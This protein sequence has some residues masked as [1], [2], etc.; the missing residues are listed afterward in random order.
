M[1]KLLTAFLLSTALA[2]IGTVAQAQSPQSP[3]SPLKQVC[4]YD[5]KS[6]GEGESNP[7]GQVCVAG[8][9][10]TAAPVQTTK[11]CFYTGRAFS[12]GSSNAEGKVCDGQTGTWK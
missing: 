4:S 5:G 3:Q 8:S 12:D 6:Y 2:L 9:W 11:Q 10:K 1:G 7:I